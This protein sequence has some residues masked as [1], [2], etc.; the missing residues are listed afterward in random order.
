MKLITQNGQFDL[1]SNFGLVIERNN[2]LLSDEGDASIPASLPSS[3]RNLSI[4]D[5]LERIDRS[6]RYMNKTDAILQVGPVQKRGSLVIDTVHRRDG[7][8]A[9]LA[10]D[11]S[12]LYVQSKQ[13]KLK[14]IFAEKN[15]EGVS[16]IT[17]HDVEE[18]CRIMQGIYESGN[19]NG[20]YLIFPVAVAPYETGEDDEKVTEYQF[21]NEDKN[22][23]LVYEERV[24]REGDIQMLVPEGYGIAPFLKLN[25]LIQRLFE[26][27]DYE[28][29]YNCFDEQYYN[30]IVIVH[31]CSDCLVNNVLLY[32]DLVPS[33]T[34]SEFLEWLLAKF[35]V[36]PIVN[37]ETRQVRIVNMEAILRPI[38]GNYDMDISELVEGDWTV[39]LNPSK[40]IVLTPTCEIEGTEPAEETFDKLMTKY[41]FFVDCNETQYESLTGAT[42]AAQDCLIRRKATGMFYLLERRLDNGEIELHKLGSDY[43]TYDRDNSDE[44][45]AFS[46]A[47]VM[48]MMWIGDDHKTAPFI[49]E[50]IHRHTSYK[51]NVDDSEQ[52]I[53]AVQAY[54]AKKYLAF[55]TSATTQ[56]FLPYIGGNTGY[57]FAFGMDNYSMHFSFWERY[58]ALLLNNQVNLTGK[59][60]LTIEQFL[61]MDMSTLKLCGGQR[62]LPV[63]ASARIGD[64]IGLTE[65]EFIKSDF[66]NNGGDTEILP[67]QAPTLRWSRATYDEN[68]DPFDE[69]LWCEDLYEFTK[70]HQEQVGLAYSNP[71]YIGYEVEY[72]DYAN[73]AIWL[74]TPRVLGETRTFSS[75][76]HYKIIFEADGVDNIRRR[77][78]APT[79]YTD[80]Q[81][82]SV[83][84]KLVTI[85]FT[86]V[87][88]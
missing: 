1:P 71:E 77:Y 69:V 13:K 35:H 44:T 10:I 34:L 54:T 58:N 36:Q 23:Q 70:W 20:D 84:D 62:L 73:K 83:Y 81:T 59:I 45:E 78:T 27:L 9:S 40:R 65:V 21:N 4:I 12:D 72:E 56:K 6:N 41:G 39:Q 37:S 51:G 15:K 30:N 31:N 11:S 75:T 64:K 32:A 87:A 26:C 55:H 82:A 49:G 53:I 61:G 88:V 24:V 47:D 80:P 52:K 85:I 67:S 2:P 46:Q 18:A 74:G 79:E 5:H 22:G 19:D 38:V 14:E 42:P 86:A 3:S 7:I 63:K 48:P 66:A 60:K 28:V 29:T 8:D 68:Q 50:R 33:C 57:E 17:F 16:K 25:R 76:A 43:F